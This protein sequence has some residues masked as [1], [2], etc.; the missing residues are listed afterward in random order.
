MV[1]TTTGFSGV[2]AGKKVL[3]TGNTGFKGS[4]L[5]VWL[6]RLGAKVIGYSKDIPT[7]PSM[8]KELNLG[9]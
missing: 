2:F 8:Y 3:V 4:W 5:T 7:E 6:L 9:E 1:K